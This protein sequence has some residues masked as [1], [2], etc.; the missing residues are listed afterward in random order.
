MEGLSKKEKGLRY[1]KQ[2]GDC[3]GKGDIKGLNDNRKNTI[4]NK[5]FKFLSAQSKYTWA[6]MLMLGSNQE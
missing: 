3:R 4:K 6:L 5:N 2:C 1:G